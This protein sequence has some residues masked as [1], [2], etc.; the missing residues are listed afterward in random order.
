MRLVNICCLL[1]RGANCSEKSNRQLTS[2]AKLISHLHFVFVSAMLRRRRNNLSARSHIFTFKCTFSE[3]YVC[4]AIPKSVKSRLLRKKSFNLFR[5]KKEN[6][7]SECDKTSALIR[8]C[9]LAER[10]LR[11]RIALDRGNIECVIERAE[12]ARSFILSCHFS[13]RLAPSFWFVVRTS[14]NRRLSCDGNRV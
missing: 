13:V 11:F 7:K 9:L 5:G 1:T 12:R 14:L 6:N 2:I 3:M 8:V 4:I 10:N